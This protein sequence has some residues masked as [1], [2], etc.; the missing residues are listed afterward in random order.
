MFF[1]LVFKKDLTLT[2]LEKH[3]PFLSSKIH[4]NLRIFFPWETCLQDCLCNFRF[5]ADVCY[6][7]YFLR[8]GTSGGVRKRRRAQP[9]SEVTQQPPIHFACRPTLKPWQRRVS[10]PPPV[11]SQSLCWFVTRQAIRHRLTSSWPSFLDV[12]DTRA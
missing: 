2:S 4:S 8:W 11:T 10:L 5:D 12:G 1:F 3:N 7:D 6:F 9:T